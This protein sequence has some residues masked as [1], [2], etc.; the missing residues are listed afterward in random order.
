MILPF[1]PLSSD[2]VHNVVII[3]LGSHPHP[4]E[5][6]SSGWRFAGLEL[7][8]VWKNGCSPSSFLVSSSTF[9]IKSWVC[10]VLLSQ[11]KVINS[12]KFQGCKYLSPWP[13]GISLHPYLSFLSDSSLTTVAH[14]SP[15]TFLPQ[16]CCWVDTLWHLNRLCKYLIHLDRE[17]E[18]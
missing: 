6:C 9:C 13:S 16:R 10:P 7:E 4:S 14:R 2:Q 11:Y 17:A 18:C 1:V 12:T 5:D 3:V 15:R 8:G